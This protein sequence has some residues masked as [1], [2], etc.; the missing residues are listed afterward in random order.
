M[1]N[2]HVGRDDSCPRKVAERRAEEGKY[3][4]KSQEIGRGWYCGH[5]PAMSSGGLGLWWT[6]LCCYK[7]KKEKKL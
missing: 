6:S 1:Q 3:G 4:E 5:L 2:I 7:N